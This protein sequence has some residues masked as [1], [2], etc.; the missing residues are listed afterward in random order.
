VAESGVA[1]VGDAARLAGIGYQL[2]LIGSA[3]MTADDPAKLLTK[4]LQAGRRSARA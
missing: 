1:T 3:L 4:L 2:A